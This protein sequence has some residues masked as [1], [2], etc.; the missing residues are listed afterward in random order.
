MSINLF[1][2]IY[3]SVFMNSSLINNEESLERIKQIAENNQKIKDSFLTEQ[4][5]EDFFIKYAGL[6]K[7]TVSF[8]VKNDDILNEYIGE[9][10]LHIFERLDKYRIIEGVGIKAWIKKVTENK[11]K[12]LLKRDNKVIIISEPPDKEEYRSSAEDLLIF[13]E[14]IKKVKKALKKFC[15]TN[16]QLVYNLRVFQFKSVD[17]TSAILKMPKRDVSV[18]LSRAQ[19]K[20]RELKERGKL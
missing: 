7:E 15:S 17:K 5:R 14:T 2:S 13:D 20:L 19:K 10:N 6:I 8:L 4:G 1:L 18:H 3:S 16:E 11:V 9:V 12:S